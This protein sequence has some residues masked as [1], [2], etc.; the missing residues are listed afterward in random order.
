MSSLLESLD[1]LA[2]TAFDQ[3]DAIDIARESVLRFSPTDWDG[4]D[5]VDSA[6]ERTTAL[7]C[8]GE[9]IAALAIE[10]PWT[11][12]E[13]DDIVLRIAE[14]VEAPVAEIRLALFR[15]ALSDPRLLGLPPALSIQTSLR[16]LL[17]FAPV[18]AASF[19]VVNPAEAVRCVVRIGSGARRMRTAAEA[20]VR[21][22]DAARGAATATAVRRWHRVAGVVAA[23]AP[24]GR[25]PEAGVFV[26]EAARVLG[27]ALER[28]SLLGRGTERERS[29]VAAGERRLARLGYDLHDGPLQ[30][31]GAARRELFLLRDELAR[32]L[33][34]AA[35]ADRARVHLDRLEEM[36]TGGELRLRQLAQSAESPAALSRPLRSQL[37][38]EITSFVA[39]SDV[40][41][42]VRLDGDLDSLTGSQR[43]AL[44]RIVQEALSN[45]RE[46]SG[47]NRVRLVVE[48][49][50]GAVRAEIEDDGHGFELE[51]T[52]VRAAKRGRMGL[53][54]MNERAL[55]LGGAFDVRS[56]PGG[57]TRVAVTL[58][59][60][61]PLDAADADQPS[62]ENVLW[63]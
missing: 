42:D 27:L 59:E 44:V 11:P 26:R 36:V 8:A 24:D 1:L 12:A 57:P 30:D 29:L 28:E 20:A 58:P 51:R 43:I 13:I 39:A 37:E 18:A 52:L 14:A 47:A 45:V 15:E 32:L 40:E 9:L 63:G 16:I 60:W 25:A 2:P 53:V 54:G 48:R 22:G 35:E 62:E 10:R 56:A 3:P 5:V 21:A 38:A 55:L 46:H 7:A 34:A 33:G 31:V 49:V 41:V 23:Y 50:N 19:W 6:S 4:N 17:A 61:R